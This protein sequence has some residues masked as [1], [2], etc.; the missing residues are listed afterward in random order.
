MP[1][2]E[3]ADDRARTYFEE[4]VQLASHLQFGVPTRMG[5]QGIQGRLKCLCQSFFFKVG[6]MQYD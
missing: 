2:R 6:R 3:W 5:L 1:V 4:Q